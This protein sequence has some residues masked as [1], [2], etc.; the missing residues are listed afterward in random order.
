MKKRN[1]KFLLALFISMLGS[2]ASSHDIA[3]AN[4]DGITIYYN[5]I[6]NKTALEVTSDGSNDYRGN[7]IIPDSV[8]YKGK[9]YPVTGIGSSAFEYCWFLASITIPKTVTSIGDCSFHHCDG[10]KSITIHEGITSIGEWAFSLCQGVTDIYY[11]ATNCTMLSESRPPFAG[12]CAPNTILHI[13]EKV[14]NI[15]NFAFQ[16]LESLT[17]VTIPNTV[18]SI[19]YSAF[20]CCI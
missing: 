15:P 11:N 10:L 9:T 3:V 5:F 8:K 20:R 19:G 16:Q 6:K 7:I 12:D 13:G 14:K 17:N 2:E 1:I 18:T 4:G